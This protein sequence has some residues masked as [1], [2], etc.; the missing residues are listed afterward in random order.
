MHTAMISAED[1][2]FDIMRKWPHTIPVFMEH[3]MDCVGCSMAAFE[4]LTD[5]LA[6]YRIQVA[7]FIRELEAAVQNQTDF[8]DGE[9]KNE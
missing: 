4:S 1:T 7:P 9:S 5:A 6:I 8:T 3:K 2:V